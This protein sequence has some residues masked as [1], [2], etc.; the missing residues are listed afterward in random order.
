MGE[1]ANLRWFF[2]TAHTDRAAAG[3]AHVL[4]DRG[5]PAGPWDQNTEIM[6][7][8]VPAEG[9]SHRSEVNLRPNGLVTGLVRSSLR[10]F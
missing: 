5:G 2:H 1:Y 10:A 4:N 8:M 3:N 6:D 9:V 7:D